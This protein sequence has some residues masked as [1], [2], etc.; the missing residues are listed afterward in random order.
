MYI[1]I[2]SPYYNIVGTSKPEQIE[3][4]KY[5]PVQGRLG[6]GQQKEPEGNYEALDNTR[7]YTIIIAVY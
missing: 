7:Y 6:T 5:E 2:S 4:D 1:I 3:D